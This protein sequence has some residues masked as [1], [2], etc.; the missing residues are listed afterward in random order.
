[1]KRIL[2]ALLIG[3]M[4]T[5]PVMADFD[6][7]L[8]DG[9]SIEELKE[10]QDYVS[11]KIEEAETQNVV[12]TDYSEVVFQDV[13]GGSFLNG[14]DYENY[15][16][17]RD[18]I[19]NSNIVGVTKAL[20]SYLQNHQDQADEIK[21]IMDALSTYGSYSGVI[22]EYDSFSGNTTVYYDGYTKI[23][24]THLFFLS[25]ESSDIMTFGFIAD[26]WLFASNAALRIMSIDDPFEKVNAW[27]TDWSR[28]VLDGGKVIEQTKYRLYDSDIEYLSNDLDGDVII[29]FS[30]KNGEYDY[31]L[32]PED[33]KAIA[34]FI[35]YIKLRRA[36]TD[37]FIKYK[38]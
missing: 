18:A 29:R 4:L 15:K 13:D 33:K 21:E 31:L 35:Q 2:I 10:V 32:T 22:S 16:I 25:F 17:L 6:Y 9:L 19:A 1:M 28:D 30:G 26:D 11:E 27:K 3:T 20:E 38:N 12:Q 14:A 7:S 24:E 37:I 36:I 23:D 8:L 34:N 5:I